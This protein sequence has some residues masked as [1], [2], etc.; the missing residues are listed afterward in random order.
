MIDEVWE[1]VPGVGVGPA[2]FG[3][4]RSSLHARFGSF[5]AFLADGAVALYVPSSEPDAEVEGIVLS[6]HHEP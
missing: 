2:H 3:M 6:A 5:R 4:T 1:I